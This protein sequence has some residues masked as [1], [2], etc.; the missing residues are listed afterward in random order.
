[1][2]ERSLAFISQFDL[3]LVEVVTQKANVICERLC[4]EVKL[5]AALPSAKLT[6]VAASVFCLEL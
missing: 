1:M 2:L 6:W 4:A 5:Q 3:F